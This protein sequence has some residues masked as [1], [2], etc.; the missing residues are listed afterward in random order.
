MKNRNCLETFI[1]AILYIDNLSS[2]WI[3]ITHQV[4]SFIEQNNFCLSFSFFNLGSNNTEWAFILSYLYTF[5][6]DCSRY[7]E[8]SEKS[9]QKNEILALIAFISQNFPFFRICG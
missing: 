7:Y 1:V 3:F 9:K 2:F 6:S 8:F 4:P 5:V